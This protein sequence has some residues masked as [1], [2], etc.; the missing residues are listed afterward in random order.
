MIHN[1]ADTY[2]SEEGTQ[3]SRI[4][5]ENENIFIPGLHE[6]KIFTGSP[7]EVKDV[8]FTL[9]MSMGK[10][11]KNMKPEGKYVVVKFWR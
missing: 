7:E 3:I 6:D 11:V 8:L 10:G 1:S 9:C 4:M 5:T 2:I